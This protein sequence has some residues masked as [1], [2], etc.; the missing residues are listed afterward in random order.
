MKVSLKFRFFFDK[1]DLRRRDVFNCINK[2]RT[3]VYNC[4]QA[5][6]SLKNLFK[7]IYCAGNETE[8]MAYKKELSTNVRDCK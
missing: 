5:M 8:R 7:Y 2:I 6:T 3:H 1:R 4:Q